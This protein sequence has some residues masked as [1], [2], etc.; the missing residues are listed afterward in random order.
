MTAQAVAAELLAVVVAMVDGQPSV[1][2]LGEPPRLP[3]GPLLPSHRSLQA[4][5]RAW[6]EEQTGRRLGYLE[7]LYTF[8]D[9][10]RDDGRGGR[11]ISVSYLGLTNP[12]DELAIGKWQP[13]YDLLPWEDRRPDVAGID[14]TGPLLAWA[15]TDLETSTERRQRV[16]INFGLDEHSWQPEL[17]LQR[18]ELLYEAGLVPESPSAWRRPDAELAA[19]VRMLGDHRRILATALARLRAKITYRPVVFELL[20]PTFTL[21]QLQDCVEALAGR[22]VHTQN[23]RRLIDQQ[24]LVEETGELETST[25]GRPA[26]LYR[27]RRQVLAERHFSG[28]KLPTSRVR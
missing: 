23:F 1:L 24:A 26:R 5:T 25:G 19:G 10:D 3:A 15:D 12:G 27:F 2:T 21:R 16:A 22:A 17:V 9:L 11:P 4:A 28:T 6:V 18:Y 20:S 8:A 13:W 14:V 7:Q